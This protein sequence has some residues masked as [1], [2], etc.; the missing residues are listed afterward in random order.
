MQRTKWTMDERKSSSSSSARLRAF[1]LSGIDVDVIERLPT[2]YR[3]VRYGVAPDHPDVMNA[4]QEFASLFNPYLPGD[5]GDDAVT[6]LSYF[7]NVD[8]GRCCSPRCDRRMML[9]YL[10][11]T[12]SPPTGGRGYP[13]AAM[14]NWTAC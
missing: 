3:L 7:G 4:K 6:T 1:E 12:R 5:D 2:P 13:V 9:S 8:V 14:V 10:R 11:T